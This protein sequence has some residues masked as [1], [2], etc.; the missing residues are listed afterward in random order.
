MKIA[1]LKGKTIGVQDSNASVFAAFLNA[2]GIDASELTVVP[3]DFDPTPLM[4]GQVDAFM[5]YVTNEQLTVELAGYEVNSLAYAENGLPYVAETYSVTDQFLAEN[6]DLL[7]AFL[8]AEIKGW[9]DT[10]KNPTEDTVALITKYY[11]ESA[12]AGDLTFGPLDP[13]KTG[14]GLEA[15]QELISTEE[16]EA[17]GLFT[18][19]DELQAQTL[20]SLKASGWDLTAEQLFDTSIIDE[21]YAEFPELKAYK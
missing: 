17:N 13:E 12:A 3:V 11:D 20:A 7:K 10:F 4:D 15:E 2:N 9:S 5:A 18:I 1:D 8:I 6:R 19:S 16:T 21:I 14:L